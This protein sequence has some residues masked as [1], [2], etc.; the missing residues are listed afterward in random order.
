MERYN[1]KLCKH[2]WIRRLNFKPKCC[3]KCKRY[4]WEISDEDDK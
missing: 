3:P 1:C 2:K 4:D